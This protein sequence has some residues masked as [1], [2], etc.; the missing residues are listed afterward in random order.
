MKSW[1]KKMGI[2]VLAGAFV[3]SGCSGKGNSGDG[4]KNQAN[5]SVEDTNFNKTGLPIVN[6]TVTLTMV[7]PKAALAPEYSEME[8]FKRLEKETNV[9]INW[10]NI[11]DTDYTEKKNL[12]IA[13]GD[14]PDAFYAAGFTDYELIN[15]GKDGTII[16]LEDLIDQYAPNLKALFERRPDIKSTITAPDGH[17]Y[18]LPSWEDNNLGTNPF[19]H[20]IIKA[21]WISWG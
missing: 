7:S 16:P 21:G 1:Y 17:I 18:G 9:K 19:F 2:L 4:D 20:V 5:S 11:P 15:Y 8:I 12:L 13:S 14:L 10:E 6:D 3:L